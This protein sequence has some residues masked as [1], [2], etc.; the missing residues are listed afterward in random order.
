M[1]PLRL[2]FDVLS[3]PCSVLWPLSRGLQRTLGVS[4]WHVALGAWALFGVAW[5][6]APPW[7]V[8]VGR[9]V[10]LGPVRIPRIDEMRYVWTG[11]RCDRADPNGAIPMEHVKLRLMGAVDTAALLIVLGW[12]GSLLD[13]DLASASWFIAQ[14]CLA[15]GNF[16]AVGPGLPPAE[17]R[18]FARPVEQSA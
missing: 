11:A 5:L 7:P 6:I 9:V 2:L 12:P 8:F 13:L 14:A 16:I 3:A 17:R 4:K 18:W 10:L 15:A 1:K